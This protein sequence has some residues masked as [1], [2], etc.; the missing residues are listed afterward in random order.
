MIK[1]ILLYLLIT[2]N[3][4]LKFKIQNTKDGFVLPS[5]KQKNVGHDVCED[6][7]ATSERMLIICD[8]VSSYKFPT[9]YF[10]E[11]LTLTVLY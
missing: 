7:F 2:I 3:S 8:G 11:F 4:L 9:N 1:F 5:N 6:S 10:S